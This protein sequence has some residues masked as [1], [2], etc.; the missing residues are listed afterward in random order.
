[1]AKKHKWTFA[2]RFRRNAFGWRSQ[3]AIKRVREA[4]SEIKNTARKDAVL[5]AEGAVLFLEKVSPALERVDSSSGA[6]GTAVGR[7]LDALVPIIATA[8]ADAKTRDAWLDRLWQA[9]ADDRIPYIERLADDWGDLYASQE[10]ATQWADRLLDITRRVLGPDRNPGEFFHGTSA[11]LSALYRAERYAELVDI[12]EAENFWDYKLWAVRA[13]AAM[14]KKA[15]AIRY[16]ESCRSRWA[17]DRQIDQFCEEILL[18]SGLTDEAYKRYGLAANRAGTNLAWFRAVVKKYSAKPAPDILAGLVEMTPGEEGKWFAA[19]KSAGLY[20][21]AIELAYR[22]PCDP[23]TLTR[24]ARDFTDKL[25]AFAVEAGI[26]ALHWLVE[27]YGYDITGAD[28]RNAYEHTLRAAQQ[29]DTVEATRQRI[30]TVVATETF[31]ER[32]VTRILG[33]DLG[34]R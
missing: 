14:G 15:E 18:S 26:L 1:M 21:Q 27:G 22:T 11:C 31:G 10:R 5:G 13:L 12:L 32:F 9:H 4:A 24:A 3:P 29:Q 16:A 19:A 33:R 28:V 17:S 8:P 25:P 30:R 34:L 20:Q 7:A 23:K 6:I 2:A